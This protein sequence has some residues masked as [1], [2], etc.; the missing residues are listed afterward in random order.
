MIDIH[1]HILPGID[2]GPTTMREAVEML[3]AAEQSGVRKIVATPHFNP[4]YRWFNYRS[5][6]L[7]A[8][9]RELC[10]E[11]KSNGLS[12]EIYPGMEIRASDEVPEL[13]SANRLQPYHDTRYLLV[14]F[15]NWESEQWCKKI[16]NTLVSS[17]FIPVIAHPE[18]YEFVLDKPWMVYDWLEA[19]CEI[20]LT[21]ASILGRFGELIQDISNDFLEREWV[22]FV[23][24]DAH[25]V[26][27]R[28]PEMKSVYDFLSKYYSSDY[29]TKLLHD[30]PQKLL[31]GQPLEKG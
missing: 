23:A 8:L 1:A 22:S 12:I 5:D 27:H 13:L 17:G 4:M 10:R 25:G 19:G 21:K 6:Q 2:D 7:D 20:Q 26:D 29:A 15:D 24:S 28:T 16:L 14:E 3:R 9:Y 18:R 31:L 30:N 11:A